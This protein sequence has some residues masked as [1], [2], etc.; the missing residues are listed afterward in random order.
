MGTPFSPPQQTLHVP[1]PENTVSTRSMGP[2]LHLRRMP[3]SSVVKREDVA[4]YGCTE[5]RPSLSTVAV[6]PHPTEDTVTVDGSGM[7]APEIP[8]Y[9]VP[10]SM[11]LKAY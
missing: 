6:W 4:W 2:K 7:A 10:D 5:D 1:A 8:R 3:V 9:T 11:A